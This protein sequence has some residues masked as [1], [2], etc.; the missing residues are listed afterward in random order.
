MCIV[1]NIVQGSL[2]LRHS[3]LGFCD[4]RVLCPLH[5]GLLPQLQW[6]GLQDQVMN[7]SSRPTFSS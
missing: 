5:P 4:M 1:S 2:I 7:I 3:F 6:G